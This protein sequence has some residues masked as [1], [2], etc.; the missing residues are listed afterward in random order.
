MTLFYGKGFC[1][2]SQMWRP[3]CMQDRSYRERVCCYNNRNTQNVCDEKYTTWHRAL[4]NTDYCLQKIVKPHLWQ[5][6]YLCHNTFKLYS[7]Q[8]QNIVA[9]RP[10]RMGIGVKRHGRMGINDKGE[11][12]QEWND[13][14]LGIN[15]RGEWEY[16]WNDRDERE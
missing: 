4:L 12:E 14:R 7:V 16:K 3:E 1:Y 10:G 15:D 11:W 2:H 13:R 6:K 8:N 5:V 9:K